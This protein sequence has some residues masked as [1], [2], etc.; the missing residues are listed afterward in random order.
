MGCEVLGVSNWVLQAGVARLGAWGGV[1][2][3]GYMPS[4]PPST[5]TESSPGVGTEGRHG[6]TLTL[7]HRTYEALIGR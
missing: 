5:P 7:H 1:V 3:W 6:R 2:A 4:S